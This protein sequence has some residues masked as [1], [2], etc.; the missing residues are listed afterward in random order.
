MLQ[1]KGVADFMNEGLVGPCAWSVPSDPSRES[2]V[3]KDIAG[4]D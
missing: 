4:V 3:D 1:S 2:G